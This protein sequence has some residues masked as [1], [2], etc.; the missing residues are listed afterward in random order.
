MAFHK[1]HVVIWFINQ[2]I[3]ISPMLWGFRCP[4][5]W[6]QKRGHD[7]TMQASA[8]LRILWMISS[9]AAWKMGSPALRFNLQAISSPSNSSASKQDSG[10]H[11]MVYHGLLPF[12]EWNLDT[13]ITSVLQNCVTWCNMSTCI[14]K[15]YQP[16]GNFE[17]QIWLLWD[18]HNLLYNFLVIWFPHCCQAM[19][20]GPTSMPLTTSAST[21]E[22][23]PGLSPEKVNELAL[24]VKQS[25]SREAGQTIFA[26]KI[27]YIWCIS[28]IHT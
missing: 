21:P 8:T 22:T 1:I 3:I 23:N 12:K 24:L 2:N 19:P 25:K 27:W 9:T 17:T 6:W 10:F 18:H 7:P 26:L 5:C 11:I 4:S 14:T 16:C 28:I 13:S 20:K 15:M